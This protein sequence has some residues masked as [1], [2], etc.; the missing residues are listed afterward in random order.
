MTVLNKGTK[1]LS[2][3]TK[4][5]KDCLYFVNFP[6]STEGVCL[7]NPVLHTLPNGES[8]AEVLIR[9][10]NSPACPAFVED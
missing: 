5:C 2:T 7:Y 9:L 1:K 6:D 10:E 8:S 4:M 3:N